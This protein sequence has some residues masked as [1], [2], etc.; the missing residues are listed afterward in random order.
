MISDHRIDFANK[1]VIDWEDGT[2]FDPETH[3]IRIRLNYEEAEKGNRWLDKFTAFLR[4]SGAQKTTALLVGDWGQAAIGTESDA[5]VE[6]L[7][8]YREKLPALEALF[9]G[10]IVMEESEISWIHQ[11]DVGPLFH[12]YPRLREFVVRGGEGLGFGTIH[13]NALE[14]LTIETGG[15]NGSV[16]RQILASTLPELAHLEFWLGEPNYGATVTLQDFEPL[17]SGALFPKLRYLGLRNSMFSDEI[18]AAFANAPVLGRLETFD[19]SMGT[20][21]DDGAKALVASPAIANLKHLDI[22]HHYVSDEVVALLKSKT[23]SLD[24]SEK[25]RSTG[26]G[27][28]RYISVGE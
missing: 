4:L 10:D 9:L 21:G 13:H 7:V 3:A 18:A 26:D 15:L 28:D 1:K 6:A 25:E 19:L 5:V 12:A 14:K 20:L 2:T 27:E 22:S 17:M 16:V 24:A 23:V 8:S 11:T